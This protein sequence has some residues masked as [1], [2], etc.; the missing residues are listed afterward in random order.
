MPRS[1]V[2]SCRVNLAANVRDAISRVG[3]V[4]IETENVLPD[5]A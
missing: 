1:Q 3:K 4:V 2:P 5:R